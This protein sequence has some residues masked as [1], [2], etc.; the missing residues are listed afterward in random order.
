VTFLNPAGLWWLAALPLVVLLYWLR[1]RRV[2]VVVP[3]LL[4]WRRSLQEHVRRDPLRRF[5]RHVLLVLQVLAVVAASLALARPQRAAPEAGDAVVVVDVGV[6]MQATD[7]APSRFE[8]ARAAALQLLS[9]VPAARVAVVAAARLPRVVQ[10]LTPRRPDAVRAVRELRPTDSA[11]DLEAAV[12]VARSLSPSA[13]VYVFSDR[14]VAGT[15]SRVFGGPLEDVAI[16]GVVA[17]PAGPD[18]MRVT[19]NVRNGTGG[20]RRVDVAVWVDGRQQALR[21]VRVPARQEAPVQV[22]VPAG[23][24]V[25]ARIFP[26][27]PLPATDRSWSV[28]TRRPRPRVLRVGP[29]DPFLDRG[30]AVVAGDVQVQRTADPAAWGRFDVVV[31]HRASSGPLPPGRYLV[32]DGVPAGL[33]AR[34]AGAVQE[35]TVWFQSRTHPLLRFV[36]LVGVRVERPWRVEVHGGEVLAGGQVLLLWAYEDDAVRAVLLPF[37]P[38]RSD[39]ALRPDFPILLANALDWLVGP[40]AVEVEAGRSVSVAAGGAREAVLHGPLGSVPVRAEAGSFLLPPF[41]R[42]GIYVLEAGASRRLWAVRPA[43]S[44]EVGRRA[45]PP[46]AAAPTRVE[47]GPWLVGLFVALLAAEWWVFSR[48]GG[49][50]RA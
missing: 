9:T 37:S 34:A 49:R 31:L 29:A 22:T 20:D 5:E 28:G 21:T 39:L 44:V 45:A 3:S 43:T 2:P 14:A 25:E 1:P 19:V 47:R 36:D 4:L 33:P 11:S 40:S 13:T 32:V 46:V 23:L 18:R 24:W 10:P 38:A 17:S 8:A 15:Q 27:D 41:D 35:D 42:A 7:V 6:R 26:Q 50:W 30:L 16:T 48:Q 12:A